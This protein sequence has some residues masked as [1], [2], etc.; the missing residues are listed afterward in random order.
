VLNRNLTFGKRRTDQSN[1]NCSGRLEKFI[2]PVLS[3]SVGGG[4]Q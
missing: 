4:D 2:R 3:V 1:E